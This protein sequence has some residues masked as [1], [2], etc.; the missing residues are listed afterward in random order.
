[1]S[2]DEKVKEEQ[3]RIP[4]VQAQK[5]DTALTVREPQLPAGSPAAVPARK[6]WRRSWVLALIGGIV[7]ASAGG[8]YWW[9]HR[10]PPLPP[11]IAFAN[12]RLEADEIDIQTKFAGR[13]LRPSWT[14]AIS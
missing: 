3:S 6:P 14:R 13:V 1:M 7:A 8:A 10:A 2:L 5:P 9:S 12:G 11:G 4:V